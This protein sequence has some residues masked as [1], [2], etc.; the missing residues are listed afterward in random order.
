METQ[1]PARVPVKGAARLLPVLALALLAPVCA[2]YLS[3]YD[4]S[5]GNPLELA[6]QLVVF[7]PLY[8][9]AALL[10]R[11]TA[12]R[13]GLGWPGVLALAAALGIVQAGIIDQSM[14]S[15]GYRDIEYWEAMIEPTWIA[16]LGLS[17]ATAFA[18]VSGHVL[19]S[20]TAP[21][22]L[23]EGLNPRLAE[24]PWLRLPGLAVSAVLYLA[25][26]WFVLRW[27]LDTEADHASWQQLTGA[28]AAAALLVV[29]A[30]TL[31]RKQSRRVERRVPPLWVL[32]LAAAAAF[33]TATW[34]Y[35]WVGFAYSVALLIGGGTAL[36]YWSRST[37]WDRRHVIALATGALVATALGGFL[38]DPIG[39]VEPVAKYAHNTIATLGILALGWWA[40]RRNR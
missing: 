7:V 33:Y 23:V 38:T 5:T 15:S 40:V 9:C 14:F 35:T 17:A 34:T 27:H 28:A 4:T 18:F 19:M 21:I 10:V 12:R 2:E 29:I 25:G 3:G 11:E 1:I 36:V 8:G 20:F 6:G 13:F 31:G 24:R 37:A 30:F 32:A 26:A 22:I 16:P 39:D